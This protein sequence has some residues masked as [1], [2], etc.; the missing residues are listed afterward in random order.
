MTSVL[1][2]HF[3]PKN[4]PVKRLLRPFLVILQSKIEVSCAKR[5][6]YPPKMEKITDVIMRPL[7]NSIYVKP[8]RMHFTQNG[9]KK[10]WDLLGVHESVAIVIFNVT[11]RVLVL[12]K[13]FR[14]AVY[15]GTIDPADRQVGCEIDTEKYPPRRGITL[16][17]CAGI[18]DKKLPLVEI[19]REEILEECGY[20]V[21]VNRIEF[22]STYQSGVGTSAAHQTAY[23]CEVTDEMKTGSGGGT[24][25]ELIEVVEMTIEEIKKYVTQKEVINSP[26]SFMYAIYWFLLNKAPNL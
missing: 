12:V 2:S 18:V 1:T 21:P 13:Q 26:P 6:R 11:R 19:A 20:D 3:T 10:D 17:V 8:Y 4:A 16:E 7:E 9:R 24:D 25:D 23:Y 22:I 15:L 14:P 5:P